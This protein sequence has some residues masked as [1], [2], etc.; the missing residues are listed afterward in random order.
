MALAYIKPWL[1][2]PPSKSTND[3]A[4]VADP[5]DKAGKGRQKSPKRAKGPAGKSSA[6]DA[7]FISPDAMPDLQKAV[8]V[9]NW[10]IKTVLIITCCILR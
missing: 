7:V 4:Q 9:I 6:P 2:Q 3:A 5:S 10:W 8:E 1:P